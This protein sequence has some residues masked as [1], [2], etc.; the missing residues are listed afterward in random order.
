MAAVNDTSFED[1]FER[2][3]GSRTIAAR[4]SASAP[5]RLSGLARHCSPR[6]GSYLGTK[7]CFPA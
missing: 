1:E 6:T 3:G 5:A 2:R 7:L 4:F